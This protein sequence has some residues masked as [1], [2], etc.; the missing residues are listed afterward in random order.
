MKNNSWIK[1]LVWLGAM[2]P[3]LV[4][5]EFLDLATMPLQTSGSSD[6]KPNLMFV[7]DNSGS[8]GWDYSPD[9][10]NSSSDWLRDNSDYNTQYY[11][12]RVVYSPPLTY[13]GVSMS[14]QTNF[15][16]VANEVDELGRTKN[17][18][19]DLRGRAFYYAFVAGEYCST[20]NLTA[21]VAS[22][23]P[24]GSN[25]YPAD[26]RWCS[27]S[28]AAGARGL[29]G[30]MRCQKIRNASSTVNDGNTYTFLRKPFDTYTLALTRTAGTATVLSIKINNIEILS[31]AV[32]TSGNN[33]TLANTVLGSICQGSL[34]GNCDVN[35]NIVTRN[36]NVLTIQTPAG[37]PI[38]PASPIQ[39]TMTGGT[40]SAQLATD[41]A[42]DIPGSMV[43]VPIST[44]INTYTAPGQSVKGVDRSDCAGTTCTYTEEMTNYAN[45]W[46]YYR[47][48]MQSMKTAAS[49]AFKSL[50]ARYRVGLVTI[51]NPSS[52]YLAIAPFNASQKQSW[53]Q[54][55][56]AVSP[57]GGTPLRTALSSVGR[58]FA[59]KKTLGNDD[60]MQY[61][62]QS[63]FTLLTTDGY[64]NDTAT[65]TRVN[66]STQIGDQDGSS[67][68]PQFDSS[69][70]ANTLADVA[71]YFYDTDIR[72]STLTNCSGALGSSVCGTT[73]DYP[74]QNMV[75]MTLGLGIDG[76]LVYTDDY[77]NQIAGDYKEI[78]SRPGTKNWPDPTLAEDGTR[79]DDLWHA[80][81]NSNGTYYSASNPKLLR[82][83]LAK[84]L[85]EIK[86]VQGA[87]AAAAASSLAPTDGDNFQYVASYQT[88][89]WTGNLEA[90]TVN[91][92]SLETSE[93]AVWCAENVSA[94]SCTSPA[95]ETRITGN[96][97]TSIYCKTTSSNQ[98]SCD[99]LGGKLGSEL[100]TNESSSCYVQ[101]SGSC[102]GRLQ[103]QVA[104]NSRKIYF[105][106]NNALVSFTGDNLT[107]SQKTALTNGYLALSQMQGL[108]ASDPRISDANK[109]NKLVDYLRGNKTYED[110]S[111]NSVAANRLFRERQATLGDISQSRP[112]YFK[113]SNMTYLDAGYKAYR[114]AAV[115]NRTPAVFVGANDGMLHA[116][117]ANTGDELW[118]FVPT[119]VI[120]NL[121]NLAD[122]EYGANYHT[123]Y[124][125]GSPTVADVC[126]SGCG[127]SGAVWRTIL[128]SG[129]NAGGRG[130]FAL[131]VT[132]PSAPTLLWEFNAQNFGVGI[133]LGYTFGNPVITKMQDGRWVVL[134]TSGYN[135]GTYARK[136][137]DGSFVNNSPVGDGGGYLYVVDASS[138]TVLKVLA[139]GEGSSANPSGL[140]K[141]TAYADQL[142]ENNTA[143]KAYAGDLNGNIWR[144]D[145]NT[146]AV[147][148]IAT[149]RDASG[150]PQKLTTQP[151]M[152]R[153]GKNIAAI[154]GTGKFLEV[155][156]LTNTPQN[157]I[158]T[159][160]DGG[161]TTAIG[162]SQLVPL[163]LSGDRTVAASTA[164]NFNTGYG[165]YLDFPAGERVNLD[166]KAVSGVMLLSTL[167]PNSEACSGAGYGFLNYFNYEKG[168][169][170]LPSGLVSERLTTP[171]VG[172][173]LVYDQNN[174]PHVLVTGSDDPTPRQVNMDEQVFGKT[175]GGPGVIDNIFKR[176]E[177]GSYGTKQSWHELIQ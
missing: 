94:T 162:R 100:S 20:P 113:A 59:G 18:T 89:K 118:A 120:S 110:T 146:N 25:I 73:N 53:Y 17:G 62:C 151:V 93:S 121:A 41:T 98:S 106:A 115:A 9:W 101:I 122:K 157:S 174:V 42:K 107:A 84:G 149:L 21:C 92:K 56:F 69:K 104:N 96:G 141:I 19:S 88:V 29:S 71:K 65:P 139:T 105:N 35:G 91:V 34:S 27:T 126:V 177:N 109:V 90:R 134:L 6:V 70:K 36:N 160:K 140:A 44:A 76:T 4:Q 1:K 11:D 31:Q 40:F 60:P 138:G 164:V 169:S 5:A 7:L 144:F 8:M 13:L 66:G 26:I 170:M 86:S 173:N 168:G 161:Q 131:D 142:F 30:S 136:L 123:N 51:N 48:R 132:N 124:V 68:P 47:T 63:N 128:V 15:S 52:N 150:N 43:Y 87:A 114:D 156:D 171:A 153:V 108:P 102:T 166:P 133:N 117:N 3:C 64:W 154:V 32:A 127:G 50:D 119:P 112:A 116:F 159:F 167:V 125:N 165:W 79:I 12:P 49:Q 58:H 55:L 130:Y 147:T 137:N 24:T 135:N 61:A 176:R 129:L 2:I 33:N 14:N 152:V 148:K 83:S 172:F 78:N 158:Y 57:N 72:D 74:K 99:G 28:A 143:V 77:K 23:V 80:A 155:A 37:D 175:S 10:A 103:T 38:N 16:A 85:S 39:V 46:A 97:S 54:K 45:W 67:T 163:V 82:E 75:T 111:L 145:I 22:K 81:V 95:V